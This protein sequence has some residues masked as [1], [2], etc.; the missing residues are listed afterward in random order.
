MPSPLSAPS[1]GSRWRRCG[2]DVRNAEIKRTGHLGL[3]KGLFTAQ[4]VEH[5]LHRGRGKNKWRGWRR[6]II[7]LYK[8]LPEEWFEQIGDLSE[9]EEEFA[10]INY[11]DVVTAIY[12]GNS[13]FGSEFVDLLVDDDLQIY[14]VRSAIRQPI[15][16]YAWT[17]VWAWYKSDTTKYGEIKRIVREAMKDGKDD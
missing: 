2:Q 8:I 13:F 16:D 11:D 1:A 10:P 5:R 14:Y 4:S 7:D 12:C 17:T 3:K 9:N 6:C 15:G